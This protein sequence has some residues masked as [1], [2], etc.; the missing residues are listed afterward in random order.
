MG[1]GTTTGGNSFF[2]DKTEGQ[3]EAEVREF[4]KS[5]RPL[6]EA[7][8][9]GEKGSEEAMGEVEKMVEAFARNKE[10]KKEINLWIWDTLWEEVVKL[11]QEQEQGAELE[12]M[13]GVRTTE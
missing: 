3:R 2:Q 10:E 9:K 8:R 12:A 5:L 13:A 1:G 7:I 4:A 6:I 11:Q